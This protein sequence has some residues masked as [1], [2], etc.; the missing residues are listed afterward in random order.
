[1]PG[2]MSI[3]S[4][5]LLLCLLPA[6]LAIRLSPAQEE[7]V[8]ALQLAVIEAQGP[9]T[10]GPAAEIAPLLPVGAQQLGK[11]IKLR[12][13]PAS[14]V[15]PSTK[16]YAV[17]KYWPLEN[18]LVWKVTVFNIAGYT[19][20]HLHVDSKGTYNGPIAAFLNPAR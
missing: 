2:S 1:M 19:G 7:A 5:A 3:M 4:R 16:T 13:K 8:E 18:R 10:E 11:P 12:L 20:V 17:I 6:V 14:G 9:A 15:P